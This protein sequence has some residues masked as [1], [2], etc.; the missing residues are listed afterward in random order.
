MRTGVGGAHV[1]RRPT[2]RSRLAWVGFADDDRQ[3]MLDIIKLFALRDTRDE[4]GFG[5]ARD[6]SAN[7]FLPG[8]T[9]I[10]T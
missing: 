2:W 5:T 6:A 7:H 4:L 9:T 1:C 10:Q 8:T 3:Q